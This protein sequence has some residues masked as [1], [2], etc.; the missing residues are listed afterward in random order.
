MFRHAEKSVNATHTIDEDGWFLCEGKWE[1]LPFFARG[2]RPF[3]LPVGSSRFPHSFRVVWTYDSEDE[4]LLPSPDTLEELS[5]FEDQLIET[6]E[7]SG[8]AVFAATVT[9][10]GT[11]EWLFYSEN[12]HES[13]KAFNEV[14]AH[15]ARKPIEITACEDPEWESYQ[16]ILAEFAGEPESD[17]L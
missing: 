10:E 9:C 13:G 2:R 17:S 16:G 7:Q 12:M 15:Q 1:E 8:D 6:L 11:R 3:T 4:S 5:Q 14:F